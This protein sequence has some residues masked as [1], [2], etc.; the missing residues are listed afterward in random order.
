MELTSSV[1]YLTGLSTG[2][3]AS[4]ERSGYIQLI[5]SS[6]HPGFLDAFSRAVKRCNPSSLGVYAAR[7]TT[8]DRVFSYRWFCWAIFPRVY[9]EYFRASATSMVSK[10]GTDEELFYSYF[11]GLA[12]AE[13][14]WQ[15]HRIRKSQVHLEFR[16]F[17]TNRELLSAVKD[18][19]TRRGFSCSVR[20]KERAG[21]HQH[22]V[23]LKKDYWLLS[24]TKR[25]DVVRL[26]IRLLA[27]SL[28]P[29][30]IARMKFVLDHR[31][32]RDWSA[33]EKSW[34]A[35][36]KAVAEEVKLSKELARAEYDIFHQVK[37]GK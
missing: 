25:E 23:P 34:E 19:L 16:L 36:R 10:I 37:L 6:T 1:C 9:R 35:L 17:S 20:L 2:D 29:E 33:L 32:S 21:S 28:H 7:R 27:Y 22:A 26:A 12:D 15:A 3:C 8:K 30:K 31:T 4:Q 5:S 11:A 18:Q 24:I 14:N 13:G